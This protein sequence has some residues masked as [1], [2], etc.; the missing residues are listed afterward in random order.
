MD[1][2][3]LQQAL[4]DVE[5]A[6]ARVADLTQRLLES[7]KEL[8]RVRRDLVALQARYDEL[9]YEHDGQRGSHAFKLAE[10]IW[11]VRRALGV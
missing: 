10:K 2:L 5:L 4:V 6:S 11:G 1:R 7:N 9:R 8:E 3:S